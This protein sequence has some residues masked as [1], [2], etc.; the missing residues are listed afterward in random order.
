MLH[1]GALQSQSNKILTRP[2]QLKNLV[3]RHPNLV[4]VALEATDPASIKAAAARVEEHLKGSGLNLL[5]NNA[6]I[7]RKNTLESETLEGMSL[8][9]TT[10]VT[11]PLLVSQASLDSSSAYSFRFSSSSAFLR[12]SSRDES[13]LTMNIVQCVLSCN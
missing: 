3:S 12:C 9:Y 1:V 2:Q 10:N 8:V 4:I 13:N 5:I 6:G 7:A 11:G